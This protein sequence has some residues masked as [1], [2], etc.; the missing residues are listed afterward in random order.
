MPCVLLWHA[1]RQPARLRRFVINQKYLL[2]QPGIQVLL[3][4]VAGALLGWPVINIAGERGTW[5]VFIYVFSL[6]A[7]FVLLLACMGRAIAQSSCAG[8][9]GPDPDS[10]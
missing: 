4:M 7:V 9:S 6:W 3:A 8:E 1:F 5:S 2:A 10:N